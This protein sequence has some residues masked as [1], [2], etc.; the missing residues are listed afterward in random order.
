[1]VKPPAPEG[2]NW[3]TTLVE[4]KPA[5]LKTAPERMAN[6]PPVTVAVPL[7]KAAPP[8]LVTTKVVCAL[9]PTATMPK[10]KIE[11]ETAS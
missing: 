10:S 5:R 9:A 3:T 7:L 1:M 4:P 11:G 6:G 2:V 8:V